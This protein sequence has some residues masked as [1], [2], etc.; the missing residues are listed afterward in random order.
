MCGSS[1]R[2]PEPRW[3]LSDSGGGHWNSVIVADNR[4]ALPEGAISGFGG[5]GG[6]GGG[7]GG[8]RGAPGAPGAAPAPGSCP[9]S[10]ACTGSHSDRH[11]Q[12]LA[13]AVVFQGTRGHA[14]L[15]PRIRQ[16]I[17]VMGRVA[18]VG[19]RVISGEA[20][21]LKASGLFRSA[22]GSRR[23]H[24]GCPGNYPASPPSAKPNRPLG[25]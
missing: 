18:I 8:A 15:V 24:C 19:L 4:I 2:R 14:S 7:R 20:E 25:P 9:C 13:S 16:T 23:S 21:L 11:R 1:T 5:R 10:A 12:Y 17:S 22:S 3:R 6:G